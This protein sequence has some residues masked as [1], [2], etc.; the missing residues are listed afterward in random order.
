ML[1][2]EADSGWFRNNISNVLRDGRELG[3]W[4][5]KWLGLAPLCVTFPALFDKSTRQ[6]ESIFDMGLVVNNSWTWR[7]SWTDPLNETE[8]GAAE[9]LLGLLDQ[10]RPRTNSNDR[11]RWIPAADGVFTVKSA[12]SSLQE[13]NELPTLDD[14]KLS[15]LKKLWKNN[16]PS[17]VSI[18]GWRLLLEKLPTRVALFHRGV[19]PHI[20]IKVVLCASKERRP[21]IMFSYT[22]M[23][24]LVCGVLFTSGWEY[25][26]LLQTQFSNISCCLVVYCKA[27]N[28]RDSSILFG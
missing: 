2:G 20:M 5:E 10:V 27:S 4:K 9:E 16:I 1:G 23:L 17:K 6:D 28:I 22:V 12:Y 3:F 19:L 14:D 7:M 13:R 25:M 8:E 21:L 18:F 15:A 26:L 11:R 24:L